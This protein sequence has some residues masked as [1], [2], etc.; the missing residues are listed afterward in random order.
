MATVTIVLKSATIENFTAIG[1]VNEK[2]GIKEDVDII[3]L[4]RKS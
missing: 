1:Q 3:E 2:E 4:I